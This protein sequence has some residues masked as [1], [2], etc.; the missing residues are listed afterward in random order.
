MNKIQSNPNLLQINNE[1]SISANGISAKV[2]N[3]IGADVASLY[4]QVL[5]LANAS[6]PAAIATCAY[7]LSVAIQNRVG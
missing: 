5:I 6:D 7:L 1:N 2:I 3:L 4:N